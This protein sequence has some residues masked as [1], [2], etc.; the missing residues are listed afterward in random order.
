MWRPKV[1]RK[2]LLAIGLKSFARDTS[3]EVLYE[4]FKMVKEVEDQAEREERLDYLVTLTDRLIW[5]LGVVFGRLAQ[6]QR[7]MTTDS[8]S[9]KQKVNEI[10]RELRS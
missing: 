2:L 4:T 8:M 9:F 3:P 6:S 10:R 7:G 1:S 5:S